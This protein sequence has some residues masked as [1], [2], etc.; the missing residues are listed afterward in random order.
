M[1]PDL[2]AVRFLL[3]LAT[4]TRPLPGA[5]IPELDDHEEWIAEVYRRGLRP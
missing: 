5:G 4:I 1:R 3:G 2:S